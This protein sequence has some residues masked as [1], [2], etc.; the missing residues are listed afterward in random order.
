MKYYH[1]KALPL[2]LA[3]MIGIVATPAAAEQATTIL[4]SDG[5]V[6][7][8]LH[9][10]VTADAKPIVNRLG[11]PDASRARAETPAQIGNITPGFMT[12]SQS[13]P[14]TGTRAFG[15]FGLP[16]TS[17]RVQST[18]SN[19]SATNGNYL[20][21]TGRYRYIGKLFMN[22]GYCSASLIRRSVIVTAAHCIQHYGSGSNI[23]GGW[24]FIPGYYGPKSRTQN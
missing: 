18:Q 22:G 14:P 8:A 6:G 9:D 12:G 20:S 16:Y 23:F 4:R 1:G 21:S 17:T 10:P 19:Q 13:A 5:A 15:S 3:L 24:I 7:R 11:A 2:T